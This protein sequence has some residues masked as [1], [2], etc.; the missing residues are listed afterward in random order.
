MQNV[1]RTPEAQAEQAA[2]RLRKRSMDY[3]ILVTTL[4]LVCFGVIMVFSASYYLAES[5]SAY[6]NDGLYFLKS[7]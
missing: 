5:S 7:R 3:V 1:Q 2:P 4:I 6:N